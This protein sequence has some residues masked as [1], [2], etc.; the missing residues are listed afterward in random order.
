MKILFV[1]TLGIIVWGCKNNNPYPDSG[2]LDL[3]PRA[4]RE[5][6][7]PAIGMVVESK[8]EYNEGIRRDFRIKA[9]VPAPGTPD[10]Q[11]DNL[12]AGAKF[13]PKTLVVSWKPG[14]FDGNDPKDPTVK[15]RIYPIT[16]FLRSSEDHTEAIEKMVNLIVFDTPQKFQVDSDDKDSVTEGET[17]VY[18]FSIDSKDYPN[19][20]FTVSTLGMPANTELR[21]VKGSEKKFQLIFKPDHHHVLINETD[22]CYASWENCVKYKGKIVAHNPANH[23]TEKDVVIKVLDSRLPTK[24]VVPE[25][26]EQGLDISFQVSA[27]DLNAEVAPRI[28][29]LSKR[30]AYGN[31]KTQLI[32]DEK[33]NSSVLNVAWSDIPPS[34]NG[35]EFFFSFKAC[36]LDKKKNYDNCEM[37][38]FSV[39]IVVKDRKPPV[40]ERNSWPAGEIKY[41]KF[42]ESQEFNIDIIDGDSRF[43]EVTNVKIMPEEM[44][45]FVSWDD[46]KLK[47]RFT[48]PGIQQFSIVAKSAYNMASA[49]SFV[50]EVFSKDR[51]PILYFTDSTRDKE[52]KFFRDTMK[53]VELMNPVIQ[54]LNE[55]NLSGRDTLVLGTSILQD[56]DL[57]EI[58]DQAMQ[59]IKNVVVAS[60]LIENMPQKFIDELQGEHH[61]SIMGRYKEI[62]NLPA[63]STMHFIARDDFERAKQPVMLRENASIESTNPL[64]FSV[65]VD[66]VGCEDVLD[67]TDKQEESRLKVGIICDRKTGG[68]YAILGTEFADLKVS[69]QDKDLPAQWLLRML[70]SN[71]DA[72]G[73]K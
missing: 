63:L 19:G 73:T 8:F 28:E 67:L 61:I 6:V 41:F 54:A 34:Y 52:V 42:S 39:K 11:I 49:E 16:I 53:K 22:E 37:D 64:I 23:K 24:I 47:L 7:P 62:A 56:A 48:K 32:K 40:I 65:G 45:S 1:L 51:S 18:S 35:E 30:P 31:F 12:P 3:K 20:P 71:L 15:K 13:D 14:M 9:T 36:S 57:K 33:N 72:K 26:L 50:V 2:N 55:R 66:R 46:G 58:L 60:A 29:M 27:Y 5:V 17:L 10:V 59:K 21:K 25:D 70:N 43:N 68:R 38:S 44:Q 69:K 4:P